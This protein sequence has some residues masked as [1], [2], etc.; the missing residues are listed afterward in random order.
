MVRTRGGP[1]ALGSG[2]GRDMGRDEDDI[3]VPRRRRPI[4]SACRQQVTEDIP[5][6]TEDVPH[7]DEDILTADVDDADVAAD[8]AEGSAA[9]HGKGFPGHWIEDSKKIGPE[10]QE[11][12]L[13]GGGE[14]LLATPHCHIISGEEARAETVRAHGAYVRLSWLREVYESRCQARRWIVAT[15]AYLLHLVGCTLF[16]NKSATHV[17]VVHPEAFRDLGQT[18]GYAWGVAALV[19]ISGYMSTFAVFISASL[20]MRMLRLPHV[21]RDERWMHFRDHLAPAGEI[22]VVPGQVSADYMEW[23]FK[24]SHLFVT[25]THEGDEPKQPATPDV[26]AYVEPHVPRRFQLQLISPYIQWFLVKVAKRSHKGWSVCST[27]GW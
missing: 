22:C 20:I 3:D 25:P 4:A 17:H 14:H 9:E 6:V 27:L 12:A 24:I 11:K 7:V 16:A 26:D 19:H 2:T 21:P 5:D 10:M 23:F 1:R 15:R 8:G 13:G 18:G